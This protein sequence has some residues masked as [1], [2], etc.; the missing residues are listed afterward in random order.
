TS[1]QDVALLVAVEV[2]E[3]GARVRQEDAPFL[4]VDGVPHAAR[5]RLHVPRMESE[6]AVVAVHIVF[7]DVL[8]AESVHHDR[9]RTNRR[10][11]VLLAVTVGAYRPAIRDPVARIDVMNRVLDD[12]VP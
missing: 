7:I 10:R 12:Q 5:D 11:K 4:T 2:V 3:G 8:D 1:G 6:L 9:A